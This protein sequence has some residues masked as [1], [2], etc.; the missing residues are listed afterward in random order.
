[1][2]QYN[3]VC[4]HGFTQTPEILKKKLEPLVSKVKN[5]LNLHFFPGPVLLQKLPEQRSYWYYDK[6][7]PLNAVWKDH[8]A[9]STIYHTRESVYEF[10]K[11]V[12]ELPPIDG[13]IG[14]SQGGAF[15]DYICKLC[16]LEAISLPDLQ[17]AV[18]LSTFR[19]DREDHYNG[20]LCIERNMKL[21]IRTFHSYANND[22]V[23]SSEESCQLKES[24]INAMEFQ[25]Q[26]RHA[27]PSNA[28]AKNA[29][30]DF[31]LSL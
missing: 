26:G 4:F 27:I 6:A 8:N 17:F 22:S 9:S 24:Y 2:K 25:H 1:M 31:I 18:F 14:F 20:E 16:E 3:V 21:T 11:F 15:C 5:R 23:I 12:K 30:R 28:T 10:I 19:F 29:F 13:I 7:N